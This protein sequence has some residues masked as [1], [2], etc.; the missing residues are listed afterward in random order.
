MLHF[1]I[2][3]K[4]SQPVC[5]TKCKN[6]MKSLHVALARTI[7][8]KPQSADVE[9]LIS[10]YNK[11]KTDGG[12]SIS[13]ET[14]CKYMFIAINLKK[15]EDVSIMPLKRLGSK[16]GLR[17]CLKAQ[18]CKKKALKKIAAK[19]LNMF[20]LHKVKPRPIFIHK[21]RPHPS[22]ENVHL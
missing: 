11:I 20:L 14:L 18:E 6:S 4:L 17:E 10:T 12:S 9:R 1:T 3:N 15:N 16:I 21:C 2:K 8:A 22:F 19:H 5:I 13:P 7:A